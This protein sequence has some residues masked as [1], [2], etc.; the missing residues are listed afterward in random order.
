[1]ILL[2]ATLAWPTPLPAADGPE[3]ASADPMATVAG[4]DGRG[5][6]GEWLTEGAKGRVQI[7][8]V[9]GSAAVF[10][11]RITSGDDGPDAPRDKHNPDPALRTRPV[12]GV[13]FMT[14]FRYAGNDR[15]E[16]GRIYDPQ[17][18]NTYRGRMRLVADDTLEVRGFL[19][20]SLF[21]AT[22]VWKRVP[23]SDQA[24]A[25]TDTGLR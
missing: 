25:E 12:K 9:E 14:G 1:V 10:E 3:R 15:F 23:A 4:P 17:S 20:I 19:G 7:Y 5:I 24:S 13:V 6:V 18:G 11:G 22:Q 16:N 8:A 21:G 2:S